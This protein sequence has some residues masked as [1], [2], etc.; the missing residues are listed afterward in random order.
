V[1]PEGLSALNKSNADSCIVDEPIP[2]GD[3]KWV[4]NGRIVSAPPLRALLDAAEPYCTVWSGKPP[5]QGDAVL[6]SA[7][8][9]LGRSCSAQPIVIWALDNYVSRDVG[10]LTLTI[11]RWVMIAASTRFGVFAQILSAL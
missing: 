5:A 4:Q 6:L 3:G 8:R 11:S 2:S 10:R 9:R 1:D 7:L